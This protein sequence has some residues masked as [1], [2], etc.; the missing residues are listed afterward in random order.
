M[1]E[2]LAMSSSMNNS[3]K[4]VPIIVPIIILTIIVLLLYFIIYTIYILSISDN[5]KKDWRKN[6]CHPYA[7]EQCPP[8]VIGDSSANNYVVCKTKKGYRYIKREK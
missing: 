1:L 6:Q 8:I 4:F 5:E 3:I 7:I 2:R